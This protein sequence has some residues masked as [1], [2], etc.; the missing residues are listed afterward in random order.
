M[1]A[2]ESQEIEALT[3]LSA[4]D[5]H[6][7]SAE[8]THDL[9]Q[10]LHTRAKWNNSTVARA[11]K[12]INVLT[13]ALASPAEPAEAQT[14]REWPDEVGVWERKGS[15]FLA[16]TP[17]NAGGI[18]VYSNDRCGWFYRSDAASAQLAGHWLKCTVT[19]PPAAAPKPEGKPERP[20][21]LLAKFV[22]EWHWACSRCSNVW[23]GPGASFATEAITEV[24]REQSDPEALALY[25]AEASPQRG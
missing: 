5:I 10:G 3:V 11:I 2:D 18:C 12:T 1:N 14:P 7:I 16:I 8:L 13:A 19:V 6:F 23:A 24:D 15:I 20:P 22:G 4:E 25:D 21:M 9:R 17:A